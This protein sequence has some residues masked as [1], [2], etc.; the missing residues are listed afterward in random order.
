MVGVFRGLEGRSQ[1]N[2]LYMAFVLI[3]KAR[4]GGGIRYQSQSTVHNER[5]EAYKY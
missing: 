5:L 2:V 1:I 4:R 3:T